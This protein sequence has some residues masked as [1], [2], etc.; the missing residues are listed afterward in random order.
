[1]E[2][3]EQAGI[4]DLGDVVEE[5]KGVPTEGADVIGGQLSPG[6]SDD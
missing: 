1:M 6:L 3:I 5:T 2:R 4:I